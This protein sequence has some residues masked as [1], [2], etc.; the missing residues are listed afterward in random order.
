MNRSFFISSMAAAAAVAFLRDVALADA[1]VTTAPM[2]PLVETI[3]PVGSPNF[4][5]VT[6]ATI[7]D[8]IESLYHLGDSRTFVASLATFMRPTS[9]KNPNALLYVAEQATS[10]DVNAGQ[11]T[12][13]DARAYRMA[14]LPNASDFANLTPEQRATYLRLWSRSAFNTRRRFY[15]SVR[16]VTFAAFYSMPQVWP[17]IGYA[18]PLLQATSS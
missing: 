16:F 6:A 15:Q 9:F 11:M 14:A 18:G 10:A 1:V 2:A 13:R 12:M 17:A 3:L 7:A 8:R 5:A 4:P